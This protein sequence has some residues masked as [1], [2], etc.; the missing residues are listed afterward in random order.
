MLSHMLRAAAPVVYVSSS[1]TRSSTSPITVTA[2]SGIQNSDLLVAWGMNGAS[3]QT[4]TLPSG[5]SSVASDTSGN[6]SEFVA[7]KIASNESGDYSFT[8]GGGVGRNIQIAVFKN[9]T[10]VSAGSFTKA[11]STTS[12]AASMTATTG[13]LIG[14]FGSEQTPTVSTAP[15]GMTSILLTTGGPQLASYYQNVS[16][17]T[18]NK[19]LVWSSTN[20]VFG[21]FVNIY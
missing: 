7:F 21:I 8:W 19:T 16:N 12:T 1:G 13:L 15:S 2:P 5:F 20:D 10:N 4:V 3:G 11:N 6:N 14:I 17:G 18:A 9:A